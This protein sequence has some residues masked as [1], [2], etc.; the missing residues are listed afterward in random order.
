MD[1]VYY[2][3][4]TIS[5]VG[6]GDFSPTKPGTRAV[7]L[8]MIFS[9]TIFIFPLLSAGVAYLSDHV[10]KWGRDMLGR[11]FPLKHI[12]C[13]QKKLFIL[14]YC[15][16]PALRRGFRCPQKG[17]REPRKPRGALG[18]SG[19]ELYSAIHEPEFHS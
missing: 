5:T 13:V 14:A 10:T 3:I 4:V 16:E 2:V 18:Y 6:Y 8:I 12:C 7:A 15:Y 17:P 9:G 11:L 19:L 1:A